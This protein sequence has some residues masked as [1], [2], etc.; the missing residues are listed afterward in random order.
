MYHRWDRKYRHTFN[1]LYGTLD[2][3]GLERFL[4]RLA[5]QTYAQQLLTELDQ[6]SSF[7]KAH[8]VD[9]MNKKV[10]TDTLVGADTR[11]FYNPLKGILSNLN[12]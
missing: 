2:G 11:M 1:E 10:Q 6:S 9:F 3:S 8:G 12:F 5:A 4:K 7:Q